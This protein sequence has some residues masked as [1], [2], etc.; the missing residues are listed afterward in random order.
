[1]R[2][3]VGG[4]DNVRV[5]V[6]VRP[7]NTTEEETGCK[8]VV[9]VDEQRGSVTVNH[10][11]GGQ[12][13][14]TFSF[15]HSFNAN[16]KQVDVYNTTARPI[17]EAALEGYNGTIFAYGQTGTG[18]TY[19]ME[20]VRSVPEKRGIIPNSFAH[21]FGQISKAE[22]NA[23]FLVRCSYL[24]IYCEDVVDLLGDVSKKLDIKEHPESGVFVQG[25]TQK[26]V[27][28]AEDMDTLMTHGNANRKVGA[29]KMNKQSSRSHAVFT[30]MIER[31]EVGEDGEEHVR[32]GKLNL[33]DL[34]GSERQKKT[35]AEGQRLLEANKINWSLSCLGN[36]ISTLVDGKSKHIPYRDSKLTRLL[37]DSLG[38]NAKTTMIANFGPADYNYDETINT[39]RYADRAKRIKNKP[40]IN[41]DPKD[42]LLREFLKQIE[43]LKQQL[44]NEPQGSGDE[45]EEDSSEEEEEEVVGWDGTVV[46]KKKPKRRKGRKKS[47]APLSPSKVEEIQAEINKEREALLQQTNMAAEEK[48]KAEEAL[49]KRED[50]LTRQHQARVNLQKKMDMVQSKLIVG[51][52]NL[53]D[54]AKEQEK[55]L[56]DAQQELE[57]K[58]QQQETLHRAL[59]DAEAI[60]LDLEKKYSSLEEEMADKKDKI[61]KL[62]DQYISLKAERDDTRSDYESQL[63]SLEDNLHALRCEVQ[64]QDLIISSWIPPEYADAIERLAVWNEEIGD[65]QIPGLPH[66]GNNYMRT[67][68][69]HKEMQRALGLAPDAK[70]QEGN[71]AP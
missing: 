51:G 62:Y 48:E 67:D 68:A 45:E 66:T 27:K 60:K 23:R 7:M 24:E 37:Q 32:M 31:S 35:R 52:V 71:K 70:Q 15:D 55:L 26:I 13:A 39:L 14:K 8:N 50:E 38:G 4:A 40:K 16:V 12:P 28:S 22:G 29:T 43:E 65:W 21:I 11:S 33:V 10:P 34:A 3:K 44:G 18:K 53:L 5:C 20:G 6:R 56:E 36:V 54:K 47:Q 19:T 46:K 59:E 49:K 69:Q 61:K 25:L 42:A 41:E 2:G 30:I 17:V 1:M 64:L 57:A 63:Q 9:S 58:Q